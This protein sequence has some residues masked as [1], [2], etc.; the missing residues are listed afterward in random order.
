MDEKL[1]PDKETSLDG[2]IFTVYEYDNWLEEQENTPDPAD[3]KE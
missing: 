2:E 3:S 1:S